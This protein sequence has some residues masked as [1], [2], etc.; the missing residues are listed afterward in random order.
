M[1]KI[2]IAGV[3][4]VV[5][6]AALVWLAW[7][8]LRTSPEDTVEAFVDALNAGET[9]EAWSYVGNSSDATTQHLDIPRTYDETLEII[10]IETAS[11]DD[12]DVVLSVSFEPYGTY[13][14]PPQITFTLTNDLGDEEWKID[15]SKTLPGLSLTSQVSSLTINDIDVTEATRGTRSIYM[16]PGSYE[17]TYSTGSQWYEFTTTSQSVTADLKDS[18]SIDDAVTLT[19]AA[20][21]EAE[22]IFTEY[23]QRC[24][25]DPVV[26][27][28]QC[29][30]TIRYPIAPPYRNL[31]VELLNEPLIDR[32]PSETSTSRSLEGTLLVNGGHIRATYESFENGSWHEASHDV[33]ELFT[34]KEV[35]FM[36]LD[37]R[38]VLYPRSLS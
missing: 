12:D 37:D 38:V 15:P 22:R 27:G 24:V 13:S 32:E 29:G 31:T 2:H 6:M 1:K 33:T 36:I 23:L 3:G 5:V 4:A 17:I 18:F 20:F 16:L 19:P 35:R 21:D 14:T 8:W 25:S 9:E 7:S 30:A 34:S 11:E 26:A 10:D 28:P